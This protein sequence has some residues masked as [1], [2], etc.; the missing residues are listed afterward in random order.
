M[1][2]P[3]RIEYEGAVYHVTIR[4]NERRAIFKTDADR[5]R[6]LTVLSESVE[7][8]DVRLYL[9]CLMTNHTHMVFETP[10]GNLSRFMHRLQT[11][12]TVYFNR[13]HRRSGHLMQ[14]R[15]GASVVDEDRYILKLSRYVHLNPVFI[16]S[17]R[18]K[19]PSERVSILRSYVW[20]T[21]RAYIGKAKREDFVDYGPVLAMMDGPK[22]T[23]KSQY[24]RFVEAG[25]SDIDSAVI[26]AK[27]RSRLCIGSDDSVERIECLYR[28]LA[29]SGYQ[30]EDVSFRRKP[31]L[32]DSGLIMS[33]VCRVFNVDRSVLYQR[34]RN[35]LIRPMAAKFL[36]EYG[37]HSQREIGAL[38]KIGNGASVSKQLKKLSQLLTTNKDVQKLR[39]EIELCLK[40]KERADP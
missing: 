6:F 13:R 4:G 1:A 3:I 32:L 35:S 2:R 33:A 22:R 28:E 14:G 11:A 12:Y 24:R 29:D 39:M 27:Q 15:F 5:E 7:R 23:I 37:G 8:Y 34:R 36:C 38:L 16:R 30:R 40:T 20:S 31:R 9:Y 25:I 18:T 19:A 17:N 26:C 21:Y 10:R